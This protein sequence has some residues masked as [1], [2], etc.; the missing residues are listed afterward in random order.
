VQN[1]A[2]PTNV[3]AIAPEK[4]RSFMREARNDKTIAAKMPV[5]M[6]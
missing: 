5:I 3:A 6:C 1:I 4:V 2:A